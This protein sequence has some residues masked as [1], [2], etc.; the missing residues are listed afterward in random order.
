MDILP[1]P[2]NSGLPHCIIGFPGEVLFNALHDFDGQAS[3]AARLEKRYVIKTIAL[4]IN[5]DIPAN[6][7]VCGSHLSISSQR[8]ASGS[9]RHTSTKAD[10]INICGEDANGIGP[11]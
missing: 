2:N 4:V 10:A 5:H 9:S 7:L 8:E 11:T 1:K 6:L 3:P